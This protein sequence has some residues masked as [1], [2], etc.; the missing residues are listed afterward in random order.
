MNPPSRHRETKIQTF[1]KFP[2]HEEMPSSYVFDSAR[3]PRISTS[4]NNRGC[5]RSTW[6]ERR[7]GYES[8]YQRDT[9]RQ[10]QLWQ[11]PNL[12]FALPSCQT[13]AIDQRHQNCKVSVKPEAD[14]KRRT[15][16]LYASECWMKGGAI[17][18]AAAPSTTRNASLY[19][20]GE[21]PTDQL[22]LTITTY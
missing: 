1:I 16:Q 6:S 14:R 5:H 18:S 2:S 12:V 3:L 4:L 10:L 15:A 8:I 20:N 22:A 21:G 13:E 11:K 17:A 7:K 9:D 19:I